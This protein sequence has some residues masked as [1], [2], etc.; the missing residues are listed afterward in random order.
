M[1]KKK[2]EGCGR[3]LCLTDKVIAR[4][5]ATA[6][7]QRSVDLFE[8]TFAGSSSSISGSGRSHGML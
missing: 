4:S 2:R 7:G 1:G 3:F 8:R 5:I 6:L